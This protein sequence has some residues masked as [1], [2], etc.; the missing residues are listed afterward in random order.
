MRVLSRGYQ[1][2]GLTDASEGEGGYAGLGVV[3]WDPSDDTLSYAG[4]EA[5]AWPPQTL[6]HHTP[7]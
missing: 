5:P 7:L 3:V 6:H 4:G 1:G 2:I